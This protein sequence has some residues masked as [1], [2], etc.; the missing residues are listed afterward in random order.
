MRSRSTDLLAQLA[1]GILPI[2]PSQ[3]AD[4]PSSF[5]FETMLQEARAGNL[6]S[7]LPVINAPDAGFTVSE[8]EFF[9]PIVDAAQAAGVRNVAIAFGRRLA[10]VNTEHRRAQ[11]V[12]ETLD[13]SITPGDIITTIDGLVQ[14][15]QPTA[16]HPPAEPEQR[17]HTPAH[18]RAAQV[19][20]HHP[21]VAELLAGAE[22]HPRS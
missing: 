21:A 16:Q 22:P 9:A 12:P 1:T 7:G 14:V 13:T 15:G 11:E 8:L 19:L 18:G 10:I 3:G 5:T 17:G 4:R 6:R 20:G 2:Q